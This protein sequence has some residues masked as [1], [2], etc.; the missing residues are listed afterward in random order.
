M[1]H[2]GTI[3]KLVSTGLFWGLFDG[4][5]HSKT[6]L[7]CAGLL[8]ISKLK[9]LKDDAKD[10]KKIKKIRKFVLRKNWQFTKCKHNFLAYRSNE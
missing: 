7:L 8:K 3:A 10:N 9:V 4:L 5:G 1:V 6:S 2:Q